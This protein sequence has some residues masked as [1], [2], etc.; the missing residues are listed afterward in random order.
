M[1]PPKYAIPTDRVRWEI[2][3]ENAVITNVETLYSYRL[4][5]TGTLVWTQLLERPRTLEELTQIVV[6]Q[7]EREPAAARADLSAFLNHMLAEGLII[8]LTD[9]FRPRANL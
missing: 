4:N 9:R 8:E 5:L 3:Q 1:P 7:F 6:A 2:I